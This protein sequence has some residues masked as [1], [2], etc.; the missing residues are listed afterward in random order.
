MAGDGIAYLSVTLSGMYPAA[1]I[2]SMAPFFG[3]SSFMVFTLG[4]FCLGFKA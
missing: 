4:Y 2:A 1:A 3:T